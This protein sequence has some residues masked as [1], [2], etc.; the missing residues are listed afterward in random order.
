MTS[1]ESVKYFYE[2]VLSGNKLEQIADFISPA[3]HLRTGGKLVHI[4]V[5]GMQE[6]IKATKHTYPD[7]TMQITRQFCDGAFVIS[8]FIM[9]GKHEGEFLGIHPSH[10]KLTF[11]GVN[12]DKVVD[13]KIVE[14]SG[15][16]NTFETLFEE[17]LIMPV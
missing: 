13:G 8:E 5:E 2:V 1:A 9:E 3:C 10:K 15:A 11:F 14:H 16:V 7:Y 4:G 12:I 17:H 6:H